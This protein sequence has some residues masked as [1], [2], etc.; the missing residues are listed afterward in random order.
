ML[1]V[2]AWGYFLIQGVRDP[3]G[4]INSL[5][6]LFGI[7]NQLLAAIALC[8]AT[9][10]ILK[11]HLG[12]GP[13][14]RP[15]LALVTLVPLAWLLAVTLTAGVQKIFHPKPAI[16]FLAKA[17][18]LKRQQPALEAAVRAAESG[19][20]TSALE[21]ARKAVRVNRIERFNQLLDAG[22]A[23]V[24]L[25][26]VGMIVLLSVRSWL[27]LL[28]G[29]Q[30]A[31]V[32]ESEPVWLPAYAQVEGRPLQFL[33]LFALGLALMKE[34]SG[35]AEMERIEQTALCCES[36]H[37]QPPAVIGNTERS[38]SDSA[39]NRARRAYLAMTENR[40][41]GVRRCC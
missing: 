8:L 13:R 30:V 41:H 7:A 2:A 10:I 22:V 24:F 16:G 3:L 28:A 23:G 31:A 4:G 32:Q 38:G 36:V 39:E 11:M 27:L 26:L 18:A 17:D 34:L 6:P 25:V 15:G 33:G 37:D 35:Q 1:M 29:R 5:W 19:G 9:T 40:F 20:D 12:P 21:G 14:R